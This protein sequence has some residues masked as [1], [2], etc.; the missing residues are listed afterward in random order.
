[1]KAYLSDI[2]PKLQRFSKKLDNLTILT[3]QHWVLIERITEAK[4]IY[5]FR[6]NNELLISKDGRVEKARWE[7]LE[8][9]SLLIDRKDES[10]IFKH[11]FVDENV[12]AIKIDSKEK[13]AVFI[14]ESKYNNELNNIDQIAEFLYL[15]Y[16]SNNNKKN[17]YNNN[18]KAR[19]FTCKDEL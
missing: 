16:L 7:Y 5:I 17:R 19:I 18:P 4:Y 11:G 12:L 14:N 13:Y 3:N 2:L 15:K 6:S 9:N 10:L 8:N 1:M